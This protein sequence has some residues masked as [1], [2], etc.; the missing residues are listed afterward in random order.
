MF[1]VHL[2]QFCYY[3]KLSAERVELVQV[4]QK[5]MPWSR[6]R[7]FGKERTRS[8]PLDPKLMFWCVLYHFGAFGTV[9]LHQ[10]SRCRTAE[11]VQLM[12]TFAPWCR[13]VIF[14]NEHSRSSQIY[15]KLIYWCILYS[16]A[17]FET[18]SLWHDSICKTNWNLA[19]NAKVSAK[20]S[21]RN[22][23]QRS[24]PTHSNRP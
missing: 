6:I 5:F 19:I 16:L 14:P 18:I 3:T 13:I 12:Q 10:K 20:K 22:F 1:W 7:I 4:M 8:T 21:R 9:L 2:G 23:S 11:L 24:L 15:S 17:S